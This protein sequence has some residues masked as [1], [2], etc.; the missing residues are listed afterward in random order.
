M[1]DLIIDYLAFIGSG[2]YLIAFGI[3]FFLFIRTC[4]CKDGIGLQFLRYLTL[5]ISLGSLVIFFV[6]IL[7][8]YGFMDMMTARAIAVFNPLLLVAVAFYLNFLFKHK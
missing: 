3:F 6:R 7:S 2:L 5:A 4:R 8:E 1:N